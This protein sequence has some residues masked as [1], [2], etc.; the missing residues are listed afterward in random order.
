LLYSGIKIAEI[1]NHGNA[2]THSAL[3]RSIL[4]NP[5]VQFSCPLYSLGCD[6]LSEFFVKRKGSESR[7]ARMDEFHERYLVISNQIRAIRPFVTFVFQ[8]CPV[9]SGPKKTLLT[10]TNRQRWIEKPPLL[11]AKGALS[12][13]AM[14]NYLSTSIVQR[15]IGAAAGQEHPQLTLNSPSGLSA[16]RE[17][18]EPQQS[19]VP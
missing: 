7:M 12:G 3:P 19:F 18:P 6:S 16:S 11:Q 10:A 4:P 13:K 14:L 8:D 1:R 2:W 5:S 9:E 15:P 17:G